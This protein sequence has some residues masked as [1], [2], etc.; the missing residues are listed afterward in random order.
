[1]DELIEL[2]QCDASSG[3]CECQN[4]MVI[5]DKCDSCEVRCERNKN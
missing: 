3:V 5:G 4:D 2:K 1:M